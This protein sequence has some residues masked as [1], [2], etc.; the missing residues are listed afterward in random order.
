MRDSKEYQDSMDFPMENLALAIWGLDGPEGLPDHEIVE[1]A[2][3]KINMLKRMLLA[4][5]FNEGMLKAVMD[6]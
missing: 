3:R 4:S 5:G 2:A 6:E 1:I